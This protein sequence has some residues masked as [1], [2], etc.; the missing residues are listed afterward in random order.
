MSWLARGPCS[1][2]A[3]FLLDHEG[4][5]LVFLFPEAAIRTFFVSLIGAAAFT[6]GLVLFRQQKQV[7]SIRPRAVPA[8]ETVPRAISLERLRELGY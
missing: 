6:A 8:G 1:K 7:E 5:K 3:R 2:A 4:A